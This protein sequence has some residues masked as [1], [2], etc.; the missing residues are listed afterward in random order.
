MGEEFMGKKKFTLCIFL[1]VLVFFAV[2][3]FIDISCAA[4]GCNEITISETYCKNHKCKELYCNERT[5]GY[6]NYCD[7]H[8]GEHEEKK[9][10]TADYDWQTPDYKTDGQCSKYGCKDKAV[11]GKYYCHEH[12]CKEPGCDGVTDR[13]VAYCDEH[14]C[15]YPGC[16]GTRYYA[17]D[18]RYCKTHYAHG[19]N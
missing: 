15:V 8:K 9:I 18:S 3:S 7:K 16:A 10:E 2:N 19:Y 1:I 12:Y 4:P 5:W 14:N 17:A 11:E 6:S 13:Y